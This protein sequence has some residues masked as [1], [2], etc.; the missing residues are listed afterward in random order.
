MP[1]SIQS[2]IDQFYFHYPSGATVVTSQANGKRNAMAVAWHSA[3][4]HHPPYY[5]VSISPKRFTH[6]LV[7]ESGEFVVNF[8]PGEMG[9]LVAAVGGC[10]GSDLDKFT[11][12]GIEAC[13]GSQVSAPVLK[14]AFAAYE[15]RVIDRHTYGDHDLFT[16][17]ILAVQYEPSAYTEGLRLDLDRNR[18]IL[19]MGADY[20]STASLGVRLD[21]EKLI[22]AALARR[23]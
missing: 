6:R 13:P 14:D 3:M 21:R 2:Q 22:G 11:T 7:M 23:S 16:G 9:E 5:L 19:Y 1:K 15:C 17:E 20:Y 8:M 12:F 18:P 4:S 10:S